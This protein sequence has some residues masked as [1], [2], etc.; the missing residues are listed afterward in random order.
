MKDEY[1]KICD[2]IL[3]ICKTLKCSNEDKRIIAKIIY[4]YIKFFLYTCS[5]KKKPILQWLEEFKNKI[6]IR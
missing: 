3:Q 5:I 4:Y 1:N 2:N 6:I